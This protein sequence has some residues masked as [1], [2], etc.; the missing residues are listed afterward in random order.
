MAI[1]AGTS[2]A[3]A[4]ATTTSLT[5]VINASVAAGDVLV[6]ALVNRDATADPS[7]SDNEGAGSWTKLANQ[8][9]TTN[10]ALTVW[11]K[12]ATANTAG[13]TITATGFTGSCAGGV[14]PFRG[15][16][17]GT[18]PFVGTTVVSEANASANE[19]QAQITTLRDGSMVILVVGCTSNDTLNVAT[20]A[21]TDPA[22]LAEKFEGTSTGG[23]DCSV[24][25][26]C[27]V[28]TTAG[29]TGAFT[30]TQTDG[31]GASIACALLPEVAATLTA[32]SGGYT[33]TGTSVTLTADLDWMR[34]EL[35]KP[36]PQVA[37]VVEIEGG[38]NLSETGSPLFSDGYDYQA[39]LLSVGQISRGV[40]LRQNS[41]ELPTVEILI[42]DTDQSIATNVGASRSYYRNKTASIYLVSPGLPAAKW[43][44]LF[45]GIISAVA[46]PSPLMWQF[47]ISPDD[48]PLRRESVPRLTIERGD[49]P[50]APL[51]SLSTVVPMIYGQITSQGTTNTGALP[52]YYVDPTTFQYLVCVGY[53]KSV[54]YVYKDGA[55]VASSGYSITHPIVNGRV[56]TVIDF[57]TDQ[58]SSII[59]CD[60]KGYE[61]VGDGS[62]TLIEDPPAVLQH[63]LLNFVYNNYTVGNWA[64]LGNE[65]IDATTFG[66]TFFSSRNYKASVYIADKRKALDIINDFLSTF[67]MKGYWTTEG[68]L[69]LA[70]EDFTSFSYVTGN[71]IRESD[72]SN[73]ISSWPSADVVDEIKASYSYNPASGSYSQQLRVVDPTTGE[74]APEELELP[75][76]PSFIL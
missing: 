39:K 59:T 23:N 42:D 1:T 22:S 31:T 51:D 62:G 33:L 71:V 60:V 26:A 37:L 73:I 17:I 12:R 64:T 55:L 65:P 52:A 54:D 67:E 76:S 44:T 7:V 13:K 21:A 74:D 30:W 5:L 53:A 41:L 68:K 35:L 3:T 25:L 75:Y 70:V 58:G 15:V 48:L 6:L 20:Q 10:G 8:N 18:N 29:A 72:I 2:T 50:N 63:L 11:W 56:Y 24:S 46:Q 45:S 16:S 27:A 43:Y 49:W 38:L 9:A 69:A 4:A 40:T 19:T 61:S 36:N 28:K 14:T 32:D 66:T 34:L 47:T 57:T